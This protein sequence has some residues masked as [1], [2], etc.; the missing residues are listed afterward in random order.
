MSF[1]A[2]AYGTLPVGTGAVADVVLN[3]VGHKRKQRIPVVARE[4]IEQVARLNLAD[5]DAEIALRLRL[6]RATWNY[7]YLDR[8]RQLK[9]DIQQSQ[10]RN[11]QQLRTMQIQDDYLA[12]RQ[13]LIKENNRRIAIIMMLN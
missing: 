9:Q 11:L 1:G 5:S 8:Q 7:D 10:A 3:S 6:Q 2:Y 13:A 4:A 12:A